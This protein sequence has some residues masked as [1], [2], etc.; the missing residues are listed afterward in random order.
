MANTKKQPAK[1][2]LYSWDELAKMKG[3]PVNELKKYFEDNSRVGEKFSMKLV[4]PF[5]FTNPFAGDDD[6][7]M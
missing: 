4:D 2:K 1:P 6:M 3:V 5:N 7:Y